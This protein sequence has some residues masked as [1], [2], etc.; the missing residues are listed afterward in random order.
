MA[1]I[2]IEV[3]WNGMV[4]PQQCASCG[5]PTVDKTVPIK[6][7]TQEQQRRQST[8]YLLG[9]AIG[10]AIANAGGGA[11]KYVQYDIPFCQDCVAR[12]RRIKVAAW[13]TLALGFVAVIVLPI[14]VSTL[15]ADDAS[16]TWI[17]LGVFA[18]LALFIASLVLFTLA[19]TRGPV[20]IRAV[21]DRSWG[22]VLT[23][24]NP[25]YYQAFC[26]ANLPRLIPY[27]LQ[28]G[29]PLSVP[30]EQALAIVGQNI[31][32]E[33]LDAVDT[34]TG[35][36]YRAQIYMRGE[37]YSQAVDDLDKVIAVGGQ[38]P[39]VPEAY[40]LR[41]RSLM[42]LG[43]YPESAQDLDTFIQ[44]SGD[45]QKVGEAKKL[46]KKVAAYR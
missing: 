39:F 1:R 2:P 29:L 15:N 13:V 11:N 25:E 36:F 24:R 20:A 31:D 46:M 42:N 28:A 6:R 23:F 26:Q 16:G 33:R 7:P 37:A 34:L 43:R 17:A 27:E 32:E 45:R 12:S 19:S 10:M 38:N 21:K 22:A 4:F 41:G 3:P 44:S 35:H 8:G 9:G 14:A 40:F 5:N 30:P 18:G